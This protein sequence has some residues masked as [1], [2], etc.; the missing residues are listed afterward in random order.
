MADSE[1]R[2][3]IHS[4]AKLQLRKRVDHPYNIKRHIENRA[5]KEGSKKS[6]FFE[7]RFAEF[8]TIKG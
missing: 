6:D 4:Q 1:K 3:G 5:D 7:E 8:K 2:N